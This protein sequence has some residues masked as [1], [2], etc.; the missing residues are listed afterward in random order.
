M[1]ASQAR[2]IIP[3]EEAIANARRVFDRARVRIARD[4]SRGRLPQQ[5]EFMIRRIERDQLG[6]PSPDCPAVE[7]LLVHCARGWA[8]S[9]GAT[10]TSLRELEQVTNCGVADLRDALRHLVATGEAQLRTYKSAA[11]ADVQDLP[12]RAGLVIV[13][14]WPRINTNRPRPT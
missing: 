6:R 8:Y 1:T 12:M 10:R 7:A 11:P 3:R 13:P 2:G 14:D 5:V 9:D 4:R